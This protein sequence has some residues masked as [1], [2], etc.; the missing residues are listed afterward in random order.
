MRNFKEIFR[1]DVTYDNIKSHKKPGL[2]PLSRSYIF[3][4][5]TGGIK[6]TTL[7]P[8]LLSDKYLVHIPCNC[9]MKPCNLRK[10]IDNT[11]KAS[12]FSGWKKKYFGNKA[13]VSRM[14]NAH[15]P[16]I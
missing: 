6:L 16:Y 5:T 4:K 10:T 3:G 2:N 7:H 15:F 8:P 12:Q 14:E 13:S 11:E 9:Y 1:K